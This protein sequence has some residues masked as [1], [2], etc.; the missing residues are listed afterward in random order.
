MLVFTDLDGALLDLRTYSFQGAQEALELLQRKRIPVVIVTSKTRREVELW[1]R[2]L[3]LEDPFV[4][5]NGGGIFVPM[6]LDLPRPT[7]AMAL[8]GYWGWTLGVPYGQVRLAVEQLRRKGFQIRGFG[9]MSPQEVAE[10]TGMSLEEA[11]LAK[12]REFSEPCIFRG[13]E[14]ELREALRRLGLSLWRGGRFVHIQGIHDK[15]RAMEFLQG[16]YRRRWG[17]LETIAL[18]DSPNDLPMLQRADWPVVVRRR[19]GLSEAPPSLENLIVTSSEGSQGW[20][21]AVLKLIDG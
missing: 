8:D 21:E 19:G 11:L 20:A 18:G 6:G 17:R 1:R 13:D 16:V 7:G 14:E 9:D 3:G 10:L 4:S 12:A 5:E 15:G 2:R